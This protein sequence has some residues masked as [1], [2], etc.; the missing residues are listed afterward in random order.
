MTWEA[1]NESRTPEE[2]KKGRV[3]L[4][5][6][7]TGTRISIHVAEWNSSLG[8]IDVDGAFGAVTYKG[9]KKTITLIDNVVAYCLVPPIPVELL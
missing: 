7:K 8:H 2:I 5:L 6:T 1:Y 4:A 9:N 3:V